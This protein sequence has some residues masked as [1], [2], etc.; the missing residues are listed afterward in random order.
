MTTLFE[1]LFKPDSR[2][3]PR[4]CKWIKSSDDVYTAELELA[5]FSKKEVSI[6]ANNDVLK[7][8]AKKGEKEK[9]FSIA[10]NDLVCPLE[11]TSK[12]SNGLLSVI[13]P[14]KVI[15][16]SVEIKIQ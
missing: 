7:V 4:E 1:E 2:A 10:L 15:K 16:E 14:K 3:Y 5:G 12:M 13:M 6:T 11:I 8:T 9:T